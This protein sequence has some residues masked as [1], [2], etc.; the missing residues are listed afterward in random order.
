MVTFMLYVAIRQRT[1]K[2]LLAG[3]LFF[4]VLATT[5]CGPENSHVLILTNG[6][7]AASQHVADQYATQRNIPKEFVLS[8]TLPAKGSGLE[9]EQLSWAE[10]YNY[11]AK[12][13]Q[14]EL[15][16]NPLYRGI[17]TLVMTFDLPYKLELDQSLVHPLLGT[18]LALDSF[19][20]D[21]FSVTPNSPIVDIGNPYRISPGREAVPFGLWNGQQQT[22]QFIVGRIDGPSEGAALAVIERTIESETGPNGLRNRNS[23]FDGGVTQP[24]TTGYGA[25]EKTIRDA[26]A[27]CEATKAIHGMTCSLDTATQLVTS[28]NSVGFY[29]GWYSL[30]PPPL[31]LDFE[32][33]AIGAHISS[34]AAACLRRDNSC[35]VSRLLQGPRGL[36]ATWGATSEPGANNYPSGNIVFEQLAKGKSFG[37]AVRLA[38]PRL[39]SYMLVIGDPLYRPF[40]NGCGDLVLPRLLSAEIVRNT[41]VPTQASVSLVFDRPAVAASIVATTS[42]NPSNVVSLAQSSMSPAMGTH[43]N[44]SLSITSATVSATLAV[45]TKDHCG[46]IGAFEVRENLPIS[47]GAIRD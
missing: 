8:L 21:L 30:T 40:P 33:G 14:D 19:L 24:S 15:R 16:Y 1:V 11:I 34:T 31:S 44:S 5:G 23:I 29:L 3:V 20:G 42:D 27:V 32:P 25:T 35:W 22:R 7:S 45:A 41:A 43:I 36:T 46:R 26:H 12:P 39:N 6:A 18:Q 38:L 17:D 37:E 47:Q 4:G 13:L 28:A 10:F 9:K 2:S